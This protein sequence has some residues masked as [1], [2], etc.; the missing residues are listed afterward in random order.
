MSEEA[1]LNLRNQIDETDQQLIQLLEKR[2]QLVEKV[3]QIKHQHGLPIYAPDRES[4]MLKRHREDAQKRGVPP[5]LIEDI[6]RRC[7]R[8]SY[9]RENNYGYTCISPETNNI[10]IIG[11]QG[12]LGNLFTTLFKNSGYHVDIIEKNDWKNA[13]ALFKHAHAVIVS[14]PITLTESIITQLNNLPASCILADVTSIKTKPMNA[15]LKTHAGPVIGLHPMFGPDVKSLA[16]QVIVWCEGRHTE[17]CQWLLNQFSLWGA[18]MYCIPAEEHDHGMTIIQALRHFSTFVYG[19]FLSRENQNIE[20]L[21]KLSSP[22]YRLE[23]VMVGRLFAQNPE[24]YA[25]IILSSSENLETLKRFHTS[26]GQAI[27]QLESKGK[28]GFVQDFKEV[29][30]WFGNYAQQ[31]LEESQTMLKHAEDNVIH[32]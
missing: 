29:S 16:K 9:S 26:F 22:I 14:V 11:G 28:A 7:M 27:K 5:Q 20:K 6:L 23:L 12:R 25:D 8:E 1:L 30:H 19:L 17:Q 10:V 24:L 13:E 15:M 4:S 31:F 21:L 32:Q 3:G 2:L 18:K